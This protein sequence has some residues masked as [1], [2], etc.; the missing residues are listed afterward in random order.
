MTDEP[1]DEPP[2]AWW[3]RPPSWRRVLLAVVAA[4][5]LYYVV[6]LV[7]VIGAGRSDDARQ[8][9]AIVVLGAAQYDG[10]PS[11]Q[12]AARLDHAVLLWEQDLAP[13]VVVTGGNQPGDRFTEAEAS[14][15][16]LIDQGVPEDVILLENE[17]ATTWESLDGVAGLLPQGSDVV[18]LVTDPYHTKRSELTAD[19]VG[20]E[21]Y[22]SPTETSV[23]TGWASI[24][25]HLNEAAGISVGRIVG[26]E[27]L[28]GLTG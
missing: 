9:D 18:L 15:A 3:Q 27:R 7:Q 14:R 6:N 1:L 12:L 23:V 17:G 26:F 13:T 20:L 28:S 16:Y 24:R 4:L 8:V 10:R 5:L 22:S 21:P 19:E 25:R 2:P 11:A